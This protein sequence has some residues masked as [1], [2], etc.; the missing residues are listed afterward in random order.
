MG[1]T[2][3]ESI[4]SIIGEQVASIECNF[5]I[6]IKHVTDI[7]VKLHTNRILLLILAIE[8]CVLH[9]FSGQQVKRSGTKL[10][11]LGVLAI[12]GDLVQDKAFVKQGGTLSEVDIVG[13]AT[14]KQDDAIEAI[15]VGCNKGIELIICS[16]IVA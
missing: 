8:V 5:D 14:L 12:K 15:D 10:K 9:V 11:F 1:R 2:N 4:H 3:L 6:W 13:V 7:G 16:I